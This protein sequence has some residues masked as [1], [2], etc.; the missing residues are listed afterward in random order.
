MLCCGMKRLL[1]RMRRGECVWFV[2]EILLS[3]DMGICVFGVGMVM[4]W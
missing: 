4:L 2:M 3:C 1:E